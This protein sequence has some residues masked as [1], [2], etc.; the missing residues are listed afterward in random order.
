[1]DG[2]FNNKM[3]PEQK[4]VFLGRTSSQA[5]KDPDSD[6]LDTQNVI[7]GPRKNVISGPRTEYSNQVGDISLLTAPTSVLHDMRLNSNV[8][9]RLIGQTV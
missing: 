4:H 3:A 1:M 5:R 2:P 7:S 6:F 8:D 9:G